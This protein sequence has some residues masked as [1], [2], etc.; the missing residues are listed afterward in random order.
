LK[1]SKARGKDLS[2]LWQIYETLYLLLR[3]QEYRFITSS[4]GV[5]LMVLS[6]GD[7]ILI[8]LSFMF[9]TQKSLL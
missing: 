8:C 6:M 7:G 2:A 3:V 9:Q 5:G 1:G 4:Q